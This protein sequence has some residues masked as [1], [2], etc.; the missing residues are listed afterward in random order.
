M[1]QT[2][3]YIFL[4]I[5][6]L[7]TGSFAGASVWRLR[8]RQL[9]EDKNLGEEIDKNEYK[10][11]V[12]LIKTTFTTDRSHC[13]HCGHVLAWY[14]LIPLISWLS[15]GGKCRYCHKNIGWFE[16]LIEAAMA[17]FFV[18]SYLLWPVV[19]MDASEILRFL[20]W[21]LAGGMLAILFTYDLKWFLLP[22]RVI[23]PFI[24]ISFLFAILSLL[25]APD[26]SWAL[27]SLLLAVFILSGLYFILWIA[28]KGAWVGFGDVKLGLGLALLLGKWQLAFLALF[29]ANI[30]G[31]IIVIPGLVAGKVGR[32]TRVPF[33][34][35][36]IAG[37]LVAMLGGEAIIAWYFMTFA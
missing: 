19:I 15:T 27:L 33:G 1:D 4:V 14:D 5:F 37:A 8:A 12:P 10:K 3:I 18:I 16:F 11:L 22:N 26:I 34:P 9:V 13:L 7:M 28:S 20:L 30:I 2:L 35:L 36:L 32:Q 29:A 17:F 23:F 25:K 21:L 6:G 31:C 24:A